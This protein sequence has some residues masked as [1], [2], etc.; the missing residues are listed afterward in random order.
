MNMSGIGKGS[1]DDEPKP[2][3]DPSAFM[4][5]VA[6]SAQ[7]SAKA[8]KLKSIKVKMKFDTDKKKKPNGD[9]A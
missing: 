4:K 9:A 7:K 1:G 5:P 6:D 2:K 3:I 8:G